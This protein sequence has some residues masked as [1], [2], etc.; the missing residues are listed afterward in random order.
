[1][2]RAIYDQWDLDWTPEV[3]SAIEEID[4]EAKTGKAAA[5]HHY[6][7]KDYGLSEPQV[8]AAFDR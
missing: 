4:R 6:E 1:M 5:K 7:L 8:R 2:T 3:Q